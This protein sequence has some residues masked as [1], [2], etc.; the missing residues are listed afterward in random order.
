MKVTGEVSSDKEKEARGTTI[1]IYSKEGESG[2]E[3]DDGILK[4]RQNIQ[5]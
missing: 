2:R 4:Y 3:K 1:Y 5:V